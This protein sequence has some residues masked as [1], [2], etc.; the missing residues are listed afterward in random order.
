MMPYMFGT[1]FMM[2]A[3]ICEMI[4]NEIEIT[5]SSVIIFRI[6]LVGKNNDKRFLFILDHIHFMKFIF[7]ICIM[8]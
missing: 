2:I 1:N 4:E 5:T 7:D 3:I 8:I 6:I